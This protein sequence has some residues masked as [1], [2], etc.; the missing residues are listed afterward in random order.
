VPVVSGRPTKSLLASTAITPIRNY[1]MT[2][3]PV[4][5]RFWVIDFDGQILQFDPGQMFAL[6]QAGLVDGGYTCFASV[7]RTP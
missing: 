5:D 6:S 4:L 3:D 1:G 7:P 2:Y